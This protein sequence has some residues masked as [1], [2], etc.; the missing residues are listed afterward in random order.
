MT[1]GNVCQVM[2]CLNNPI[3]RILLSKKKHRTILTVRRFICSHPEEAFVMDPKNWTQ[4]LGIGYA[5][6]ERSMMTKRRKFIPELKA[7]VV[8]ELISGEISSRP[9]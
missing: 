5:P 7:S 6:G 2:A 1:K 9:D 8:L 4:P 3:L